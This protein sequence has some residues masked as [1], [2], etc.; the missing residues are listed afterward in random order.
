MLDRFVR[1]G[2][3]SIFLRTIPISVEKEGS[4]LR[5]VAI[6]NFESRRFL[7]LTASVFV[8]A[9]ELG[10]FL[11]LSGAEYVTGAESRAETGEPDA[12]PQA[13]PS[14]AQSF[15]YAFVLEQGKAQGG[16][17]KPTGYERY[18]PHFSFQSTNAEGKT[19]TYGMYAQ[20]PNTPGSTGCE[21]AIQ[22]GRLSL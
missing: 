21:G 8:D 7:R 14:A 2:K 6:Y 22:A 10:E 18:A 3:L 12:P 16:A 15:T 13:D 17:A 19:L 11:P 20:L 1:N 9:T 4:Q 5:A